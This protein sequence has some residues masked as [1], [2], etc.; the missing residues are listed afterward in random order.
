MGRNYII[1]TCISRILVLNYNPR[2]LL[3]LL[4]FPFIIACMLRRLLVNLLSR[5]ANSKRPI[6][7]SCSIGGI[8]SCTTIRFNNKFSDPVGLHVARLVVSALGTAMAL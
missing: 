6:D 5:S 8:G 1:P 7:G 2:V 3:R 4:F